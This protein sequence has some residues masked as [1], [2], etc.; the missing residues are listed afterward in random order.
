MDIRMILKKVRKLCNSEQ[1]EKSQTEAE[2]QFNIQRDKGSCCYYDV[3][4]FILIENPISLSNVKII[5]KTIPP[6]LV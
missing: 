5:D 2:L 1:K 6:S 3:I 4:L